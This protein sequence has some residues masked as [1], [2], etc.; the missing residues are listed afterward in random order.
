VLLVAE[1]G[2]WEEVMIHPA[3]AS[4]NP[5][6]PLIRDANACEIMLHPEWEAQEY[7]KPLMPHF[8]AKVK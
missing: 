3:D 4:E 5:V 6:A 7:V 8:M 1:P 2:V